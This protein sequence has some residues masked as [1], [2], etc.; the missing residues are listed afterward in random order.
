M[1]LNILKNINEDETTYWYKMVAEKMNA[2]GGFNY[3]DLNDKDTVSILKDFVYKKMYRKR[4]GELK[5]V[6]NKFQITS[7]QKWELY[8]FMSMAYDEEQR[9]MDVTFGP[10]IIWYIILFIF[11]AFYMGNV[12]NWNFDNM[13]NFL[14]T[15]LSNL[16]NYSIDIWDFVR[17]SEHFE[18]PVGHFV[19][20][21]FLIFLWNVIINKISDWIIEY[22]D[23]K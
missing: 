12:L 20:L 7:K 18:I 16:L 22:I 14:P 11:A 9:K 1:T 2:D 13:F 21:W 10:Q 4:V 23:N 5:G 17:M 8:S 3:I 6:I 15:S 19:L